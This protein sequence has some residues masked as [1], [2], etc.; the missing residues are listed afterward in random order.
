MSHVPLFCTPTI[1]VPLRNR[2]EA[3]RIRWI[4]MNLGY[5]MWKSTGTRWDIIDLGYYIWGKEYER[6][7]QYNI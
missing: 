1:N 7:V 2:M 3:P 6:G 4:G 5:H